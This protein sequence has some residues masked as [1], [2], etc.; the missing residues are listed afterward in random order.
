MERGSV[1]H[2]AHVP[3]QMP[4]SAPPPCTPPPPEHTR[5]RACNCLFFVVCQALSEAADL[6]AD[7]DC[8]VVFA[9][10]GGDG[11]VSRLLAKL[12]GVGEDE[13]PAG[14]YDLAAAVAGVRAACTVPTRGFPAR[15]GWRCVFPQLPSCLV[16]ARLQYGQLWSADAAKHTSS[17]T[18]A[19]CAHTH[20]PVF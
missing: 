10:R 19:H 15:C 9:N 1:R 17:S 5:L 7:E 14:L 12:E 11:P 4:V 18:L 16:H 8:S 6:C 2:G 13:D 3:V 20:G